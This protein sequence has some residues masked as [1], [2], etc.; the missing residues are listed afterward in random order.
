MSII[1]ASYNDNTLVDLK[2]YEDEAIVA[3][4]GIIPKTLNLTSAY[5]EIKIMVWKDMTVYTP[6][7]GA[8]SFK[9]EN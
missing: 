4:G 5:D 8:T 7:I 9:P 1:I 3:G 6:W 2:V